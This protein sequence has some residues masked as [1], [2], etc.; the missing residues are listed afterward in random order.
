MTWDPENKQDDS[1]K[2]SSHQAVK[3]EVTISV[4]GSCS[5]P[6]EPPPAQPDI[7]RSNLTRFSHPLYF[8]SID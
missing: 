8:F 5:I 2:L 1:K 3:G 7:G 6:G 4:P